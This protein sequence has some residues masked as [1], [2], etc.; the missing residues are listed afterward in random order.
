MA[1]LTRFF[2]AAEADDAQ[3]RLLARAVNREIGRTSVQFSPATVAAAHAAVPDRTARAIPAGLEPDLLAATL[4]VY[5]DLVARSAVFNLVQRLSHEAEPL[6]YPEAVRLFQ[7]M[8]AGSRIAR[9]YPADVAALRALARKHP[10]VSRVRPDSRRAAQLALHIGLVK[11]L[12][13][14][15]DSAG[16]ETYP[17]PM[18]IVWKR[19]STDYGRIDGTIGGVAFQVTYTKADGWTVAFYA[20]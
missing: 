8:R 10:P 13:N 6:T 9:Q 14:G 12:N 11:G 16:G 5:S 7:M 2:A 4:L 17:K 1:S 18:R 19:I 20:C 3:I 15:C